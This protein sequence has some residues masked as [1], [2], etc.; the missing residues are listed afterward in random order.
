MSAARLQHA[1]AQV[2]RLGAGP[3]APRPSGSAVCNELVEARLQGSVEP[4]HF[5]RLA[6]PRFAGP[7]PVGGVDQPS[8]VLPQPQ[9]AQ[10]PARGLDHHG[11][12]GVD[13]QPIGALLEILELGRD[14]ACVG[15]L[16]GLAGLRLREGLD[17]ET[18]F[19]ADTNRVVG[20]RAE[21]HCALPWSRKARAPIASAGG[22]DDRSRSGHSVTSWSAVPRGLLVITA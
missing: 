4:A 11:A 21:Q 19:F 7:T 1:V 9:I 13:A 18:G 5:E 12:P 3:A 10:A 2:E 15:Q 17:R 16:H 8:A 14:H 22:A 20:P 6:G